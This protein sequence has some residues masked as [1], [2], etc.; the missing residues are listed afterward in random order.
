MMQTPHTVLLA[1]DHALF[2][3]G[4]CSLID[5][6]PD[7][8]VIGQAHCAES[9]RDLAAEL[10][11]HLLVLDIAMPGLDGITA[12]PLIKQASADTRVLIVSMYGTTDFVMQSLRAGADGYLL[13][14]AAAVELNIAL[15]SLTQGHCYLCPAVTSAVVEEALATRAN[16]PPAAAASRSRHS[17]LP[18]TPR[19]IEILQMLV[20]GHSVKEIAHELL[21]SAKTVEAHRAQILRR[22]DIRN[23]PQLVL[24]AVRHGLIASETPTGQPS[25]IA[26]RA[27]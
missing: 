14:D 23:V 7:Y 16:P 1:D 13:K 9:A 12:L 8:Q 3:E 10:R 26:S 20:N 25:E 4:L 19:Q 15:Q 11:P 6:M 22:L 24:Y 27:V 5:D 18:L 2:R 17:D 21:L